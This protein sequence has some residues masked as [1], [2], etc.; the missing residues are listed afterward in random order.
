MI[1]LNDW[2]YVDGKEAQ[3]NYDRYFTINNNKEIVLCIYKDN[4]ITVI[5]DGNT[6]DIEFN[7]LGEAIE[8]ALEE[9]EKEAE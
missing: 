9:T 4:T 7:N 2:T 5:I 1:N 3:T 6:E 8:Y